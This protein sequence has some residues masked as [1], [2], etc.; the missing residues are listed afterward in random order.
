VHL[1]GKNV[2]DDVLTP[3]WTDYQKHVLYDSYDV[4]P[5][6]RAG[7]NAVGVMLGNGM[8]NALHTPGRYAQHAKSYGPPKLLLELRVIYA[9]G[10][11]QTIVSNTSWKTASGPITFSNTYGGEDYDARLVQNGWD[12]PGFDDAAWSTA[13]ITTAPNAA[14]AGAMEAEQTPPV[15]VLKQFA[16]V[17]MNHPHDGLTVYDLGQN[18]AG[19][20][21]ITVSGPAGAMVTMLPGELLNAD[22]TVTQHSANAWPGS[23]VL[24]RYTLRGGG[25]ESWHPRFSYYG[26]RYLQIQTTG[27]AVQIKSL[28][29]ERTGADV[30]VTGEFE[31]SNDLFNRIHQLILNAVR[32]N[33]MSILTDCPH[34]EKLGWLEETHLFAGSLMSNYD[35]SSFYRKMAEDIGDGQLASGLVPSIAPEYIAFVDNKGNS[36]AF[37][38]SPEWGSAIVLS[39]WAA[40]QSYGDPSALRDHYGELQHYMS[41]LQSRSKNG[42]LSYGLGD[43]YD[44]GPKPPGYSQL[45]STTVTATATYYEDLKAMTAIAKLL[46]KNDDAAMYAQQASAVRD[47]YNA[48]LFHPATNEYDR[49]SQTANAMPLALGMVPADKR[50]AVMENLVADIAAH[51]YHVTAGDVGFHYVV[52][53]LTDGGRSDVLYRMMSQTTS[54]S[55]GYQ[56]AKGATALTEAWDTNPDSSQDHFMLGHGEEWFY[57]GL[58]GIDFDMSRPENERLEIRPYVPEGGDNATTSAS[59]SMDTV[60]GTVVS[61]WKRNGNVVEW[62]VTV[63]PNASALVTFPAAFQRNVFESGVPLARANGVSGTDQAEVWKVISGTYHFRCSRSK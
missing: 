24:F 13:K 31:S 45:S 60:L 34:R 15:R 43:W 46:G 20:P 14:A 9:D 52:R 11:E 5:L 3:G 50:A 54:P 6:L 10:S 62:D 35:V 8:Y 25:E 32:S 21:A 37:R 44:I 53:A 39:A 22:G 57:R 33:V 59:A 55:Y 17:K 4:L 7:E 38:D 30:R 51:S 48:A 19:W 36:T 12:T 2:T 27:G 42:L 16:P 26:F 41:Y 29:G 47:T 63:P 23:P 18:F 40:Y 1:N 56:L 28:I 58:A 61:K 49:G